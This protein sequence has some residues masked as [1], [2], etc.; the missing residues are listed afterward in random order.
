MPGNVTVGVHAE[1]E[2]GFDKSNLQSSV[3]ELLEEA[4]L[5]QWG[6]GLNETE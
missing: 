1:S 2:Q 4:D 6:T 3:L 5:I